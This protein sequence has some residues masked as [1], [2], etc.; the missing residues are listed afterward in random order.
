MMEPFPVRVARRTVIC[1]LG[2]GRFRRNMKNKL[3]AITK[4]IGLPKAFPTRHLSF[5]C[6]RNT[7]KIHH[8]DRRAV[9]NIFERV[10]PPQCLTGT[11]FALESVHLEAT[12]INGKSATAQNA[13]SAFKSRGI[14]PYNPLMIP[15][16]TLL[17]QNPIYS[18]ETSL[19][20]KTVQTRPESTQLGHSCIQNQKTTFNKSTATEDITPEKA[21]DDVSPIPVIS[22]TVK[23]VR[24]K[25]SGDITSPEF[26]KRK[27]DAQRKQKIG[28]NLA[29]S[30]KQ[31]KSKKKSL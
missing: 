25:I 14:L 8:E 23:R 17:V 9:S 11:C 10:P 26:I 24:K 31:K 18:V 7:T 29:M 30:S 6:Q 19:Q 1:H 21:L 2:Y 20:N 12:N 22:L 27:K 16:Y 13:I 15:D 4:T 5:V 3:N 28:F